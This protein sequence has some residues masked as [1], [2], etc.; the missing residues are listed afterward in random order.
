MVCFSFA[1]GIWCVAGV[2]SVSPSSEQTSNHYPIS[3]LKEQSEFYFLFRPNCINRRTKYADTNRPIKAPWLPWLKSSPYIAILYSEICKVPM[4]DR[5]L[6]SVHLNKIYGPQI[7]CKLNLFQTRSTR[8]AAHI[9][10]V[11]SD[12]N[13]PKMSP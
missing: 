10:R 1:C 11:K 12:V 4:H 7:L 6:G 13:F 8:R 5:N 9:H 2:S 3:N